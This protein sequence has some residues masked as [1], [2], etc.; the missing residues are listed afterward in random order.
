MPS[1][2]SDETSTRSPPSD[3][4]SSRASRAIGPSTYA[5]QAVG[6]DETS[7]ELGERRLEQL[8]DVE[9][10]PPVTADGDDRSVVRRAGRR[11]ARRPPAAARARAS[12][13]SR[14]CRRARRDAQGREPRR[15]ARSR[16]RTRSRRPTRQN[17]SASGN[18]SAAGSADAL[19]AQRLLDRAGHALSLLDPWRSGHSASSTGCTPVRSREGAKYTRRVKAVV[20][21][22]PHEAVFR[23]VET[24]VCGPGDVL[25]R[26]RL[27]GVCRTDIEVLNGELDSRWVRYPC[28]P[29][30]EWSGIVEAVGEGVRDLE[31]GDRVVCE[32]FC[33]CGACRRCRAG[34]THLCEQL[35]LPRLHPRRRL[36][37]ARARPPP[38]CPPPAG[39]GPA[40]RRR[41]DRARIGGAQGAAARAAQLPARRSALS[42]PARSGRWRSCS[43][44]CSRRPRSSPTAI[45]EQE[46]E[47]A[48]RLGADETVDVS[49]GGAPHEGG[50]DLVVETAGA[51][52]A[53][54][55]ATR[56]PREGGRV[57]GLG[58]S[59]EGRELCLPADRFVLRDLELIGSVGYTTAVWSRVVELL[60]AGLVDFAPIVARRVPAERFEDAFGLMAEPDGVVGQNPPRARGA[61][62]RPGRLPPPRG[63]RG[64]RRLALPAA[65]AGRRRSPET[66]AATLRRIRAGASSSSATRRST[67]SSSRRSSERRTRLRSSSARCSGRAR[68]AATSRRR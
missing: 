49:G 8:A 41:S 17:A 61:A 38:R 21:E 25:V 9:R 33:Y 14:R 40:R 43:P 29:G 15:S 58:I 52:A 13:S 4:R 44:G 30:H 10:H 11:R 24:P 47:L 2:T 5:A 20:I 6:A 31:P 50:L 19:E 56:L 46:L 60:G 64:G 37:R 36:R 35:R 1:G 18:E 67:R 42:A 26:S 55:L 65:R 62:D 28:I 57:V 66:A 12:R 59:G 7:R 53:V 48:R 45:R 51:V 3:A 32:G 34:D 54:E 63:R 27:A 68:R 22:R 23:E 16:R 39:R